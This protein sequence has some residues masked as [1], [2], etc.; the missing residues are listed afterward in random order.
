MDDLNIEWEENGHSSNRILQ[1]AEVVKVLEF[2]MCK[3]KDL[4]VKNISVIS[5]I[6]FAAN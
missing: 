5:E 2:Q 4:H 1:S 6:E 3:V